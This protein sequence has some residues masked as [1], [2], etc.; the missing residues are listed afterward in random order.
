MIFHQDNAPIHKASCTK[1]WLEEFGIK[2][3][4]W[5][6]LS[7]DL[8]PIEDL[9]SI[10]ERKVYGQGKPQIQNVH[11]LKNRIESAWTDIP[12]ETLNRLI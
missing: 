4:P 12:N 8:N 6:A 2:L 7:P 9:W 11:E 3:L 10:L 1:R 5:P